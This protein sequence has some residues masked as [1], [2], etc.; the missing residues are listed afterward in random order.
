MSTNAIEILETTKQDWIEAGLCLQSLRQKGIALPVTDALIVAIV[1][2]H[3]VPV[4]TIDKH[5]EH[6][7]VDT[8]AS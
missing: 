3:T 5:F 4:L 8:I 6:L 1:L 7:S 2:P